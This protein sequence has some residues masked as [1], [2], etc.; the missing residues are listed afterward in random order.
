MAETVW[1][2]RIVLVR[3]VEAADRRLV[4]LVAGGRMVG[5][6]VVRAHRRRQVV[7]VAVVEVCGGHRFRSQTNELMWRRMAY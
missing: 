2:L 1:L 6:E 7:V 3:I 4:A 5:V